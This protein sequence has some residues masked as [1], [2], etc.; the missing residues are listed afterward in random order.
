MNKDLINKIIVI[1]LAGSVLFYLIYYNNRKV[2]AVAA[3]EPFEV[4]SE[5]LRDGSKGIEASEE[6]NETYKAV[7]FD[8]K[9]YPTD[10]FPRDKLTASDLLPKDAANSTW[11]KVNPSGQGSVSD[12]NFVNAG[13]HYGINTVGNSLRNANLQIR[14]EPP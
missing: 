8:A 7:D 6:K 4:N 10:C 12:Q 3:R 13:Y 2:G 5:L 11:S 14:S 1:S 9:Q